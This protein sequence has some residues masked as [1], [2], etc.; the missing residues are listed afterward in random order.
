VKRFLI[1]TMAVVTIL[2]SL[3]YVRSRFLLVEMSY[4]IAAKREQKSKLDQEKRELTL[5]LATL[6]SSSRIERIAARQLNLTR[7]RFPVQEIVVQSE[8]GEQSR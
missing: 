7:P 5:E 3:L 6:Q 2:A 8:A 4:E 1:P